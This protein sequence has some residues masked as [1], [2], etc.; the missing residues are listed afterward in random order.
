MMRTATAL[1]VLNMISFADALSQPPQSAAFEVASLKPSAPAATHTISISPYGGS[2]F[3]AR[4]VTLELLICLAFE[5]QDSQ[6]SGLPAWARSGVYDL[7]AK[8][9]SNEPVT[10]EKLKPLMQTL[11]AERFHLEFAPEGSTDSTKPSI[12]TAIKEQLGLRLET[13]S[14]PHEILVIDHIEKL[15]ETN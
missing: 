14:V 9:G 7:A 8:P 12:F 4:N 1:L 2:Q 11:L 15:V 5:V 6:I 3:T 13:H 10:Y